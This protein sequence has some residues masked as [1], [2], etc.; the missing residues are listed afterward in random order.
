MNN[1]TSRFFAT[2]DDKTDFFVYNLP[3]SW[4]SRKYEYEWMKNF[5]EPNDVC[6]DAASGV[7]HPLKFHLANNCKEVY[8]C[9]LD[10]NIE[11]QNLKEIDK[12]ILEE[13]SIDEVQLEKIHKIEC[14]KQIHNTRCSITELPYEDKMFDKIFCISVL[15]HLNDRFNKKYDRYKLLIPFINLIHPK[16]LFKTMKEFK[17]T[18]KDE[19]T[20]VLTFDYPDISLNYFK[21]VLDLLELEFASDFN[22]DLPENAIYSDSY[23]IHC[24]RAVIKKKKN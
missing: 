6:L 1:L 20:I 19:G 7:F 23:N 21:K 3:E 8:A 4:W 17:R 18:L 2:T 24:F 14:S 10:E 12:K 15:E 9:D 11:S 22:F 16:D 13:N 5:I